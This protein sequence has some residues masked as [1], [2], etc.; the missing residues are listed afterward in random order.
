ML[1]GAEAGASEL[2]ARHSPPAEDALIGAGQTRRGL[3]AL[4]ALDTVHSVF[5]TA[6]PASHHGLD[7]ERRIKR[8]RRDITTVAKMNRNAD[9]LRRQLRSDT[10]WFGDWPDCMQ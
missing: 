8:E 3:H 7:Q 4:M 5:V 9:V 10:I 6:A 1:G 2:H